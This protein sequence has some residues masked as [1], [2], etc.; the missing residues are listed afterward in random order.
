M[1]RDAVACEVS[2]VGLQRPRAHVMWDYSGLGRMSCGTR[3]YHPT[4]CRHVVAGERRYSGNM[5][6]P[7]ILWACG[8]GLGEVFG[9]ILGGI[10]QLS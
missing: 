3:G 4:R 1:G 9:A 2:H 10:E 8:E 5:S 6:F 7:V